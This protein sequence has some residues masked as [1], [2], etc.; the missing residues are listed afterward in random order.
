MPAKA[1]AHPGLASIDP[2]GAIIM[3]VSTIIFAAWVFHDTPI[4]TVVM[5]T[6]AVYMVM[7]LLVA[8]MC[9]RGKVSTS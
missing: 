4:Q 8:M 2:L 9:K 6:L 1:P 3:I 5:Y 7:A